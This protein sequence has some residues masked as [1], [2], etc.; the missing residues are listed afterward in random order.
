MRSRCKNPNASNFP[1]YGGRGISVCARWDSFENFFADM[2]PR[3]TLKYSLDRYPNNDGNYE[4]DNVRWATREQQHRNTRRNITVDLRGEKMILKD[5]ARQCGVHI[6][7][8]R[9]RIVRDKWPILDALTTP[10]GMPRP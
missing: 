4:P 8:V 2:G 1:H 7:T 9:T 6:S 5:A 3:P 10:P